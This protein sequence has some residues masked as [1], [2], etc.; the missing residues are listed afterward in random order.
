MLHRLILLVSALGL[1]LGGAT[2]PLTAAHAA[3]GA[4]DTVDASIDG[5]VSGTFTSDA[6]RAI[7]ELKGPDGRVSA[8]QGYTPMA[9]VPVPFK[10]EAL[11]LEPGTT[12]TLT[13][14]SCD[15]AWTNC[16]VTDERT[17]TLADAGPVTVSAALADPS[18]I[19]AAAQPESSIRVTLGNTENRVG[20]LRMYVE[21]LDADGWT[22]AEFPDTEVELPKPATATYDAEFRPAY[23]SSGVHRLRLTVR[24]PRPG[25]ITSTE[26]F[27]VEVV[28]PAPQIA[29]FTQSATSVYPTVDGYRDTVRFTMKPAA[30]DPADAVRLQIEDG[31]AGGIVR[32]LTPVSATAAGGYVFEWNGR[33]DNG[34]I[35]WAGPFRAE[36]TLR[37]TV[38]RAP[39]D[40]A[41][42]WVNVVRKHLE[43]RLWSTTVTSAATLT[44]ASVGGCST[45]RKPA[46]SGW[47]G[48]LGLYSNTRCRSTSGAS[49]VRTFH[50]LV[51]PSVPVRDFVRV[52]TYGGSPRAA[53]TDAVTIRYRST[54][55][56]WGNAHT[57]GAAIGWRNGVRVPA[58]TVL[59]SGR[60][61]AWDAHVH[62]G[63]RW[64]L[65][66]F[67]VVLGYRA[68]VND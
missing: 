46:R 31:T 45:L 43:P 15:A 47:S 28:N 32:T 24:G 37:D 59:G 17:V 35:I 61:L 53:S 57:H 29:S 40:T 67:R 19:V 34:S 55:A 18:P 25:Q 64:D 4:F 60:T 14:T 50:D 49:V 26:E 33:H 56:T 41:A 54:G 36:V 16:T 3:T 27:V 23:M 2:L 30:F 58:S 11:V 22:I 13:L 8:R 66:R 10:A 9:G 42:L 68:L 12:A 52:D 51:L 38:A 48:S 5:E 65:G 21:W 62:S 6:G 39:E 1:A 44:H 7:V 20:H 63:R